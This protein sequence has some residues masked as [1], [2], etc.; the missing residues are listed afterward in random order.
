[1]SSELAVKLE[2]VGKYY[3]LYKRPVDRLWQ[4]LCPGRRQ[5]FQPCWACRDISLEI[6]RG[7]CLGIIGRNGAGK[8]T[9]LQMIAGTL[10]PSAGKITVNG[11]V[12]ALLELGSGFNPE[13]SGRENVLLNASIL[14]LDQKEITACYPKI[15]EF[16]DIGDFIDRPV[17]TYSSGMALRLAFAVM[18]NVKA[19]IL[20]IDEALA[21]GDAFFTQKCMRFLRDFMTSHTVIFVSHDTAAVCSLCNRAVL[22]ENGSIRLAG[23]PREVARIYL[24]DLYRGQQERMEPEFER[25]PKSPVQARPLRD[26]RADLFNSSTLRNDIEIFQFRP[27]KA[28][29]GSG[30]A[31]ITDVWLANADGERYAW[32]V[33]GETVWLHIRAQIHAPVEQPIIGFIVLNSYGQQLFGDNTWLAFQNRPLR[34]RPG[35]TLLADFC[36]Q[37]PL[38]ATGDYHVTAAI[39]EGTPKKH[40]QHHWLHEAMAFKV[41]S[42][43]VASGLVGAPM[44]AVN[45]KKSGAGGDS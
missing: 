21:V 2:S 37:M 7:E 32:L 36:F 44:L 31:E 13:F 24:E 14:G 28:G 20:I 42:T 4:M 10:A 29:F 26:M 9:L 18:A 22:L 27:E 33:G 11:R 43:S 25:K 8:S 3:E 5:F 45:M 35:D 17:K 15:A 41:H 19:D 30:N 1:M 23:S 34:C 12:A 38:L 40:I 6:G 39:G 16:A